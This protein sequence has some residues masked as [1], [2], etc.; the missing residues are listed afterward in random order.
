MQFSNSI[1]FKISLFTVLSSVFLFF[2]S[3]SKIID[4]PCYPSHWIRGTMF[5][6]NIFAKTQ[7]ISRTSFSLVIIGTYRVFSHQNGRK[8]RETVTLSF[9]NIAEIFVARVER[10]YP[11]A[12]WL[13]SIYTMYRTQQGENKQ[14]YFNL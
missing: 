6:A 14:T 8:S 12:R 2:E 4:L 7:K 5:I 9:P 1:Q 3:T 10:F 13:Y 11:V